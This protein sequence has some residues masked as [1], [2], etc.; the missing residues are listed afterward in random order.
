MSTHHRN[1]YR[2]LLKPATLHWLSCFWNTVLL[3]MKTTVYDDGSAERTPKEGAQNYMDL[4][5]F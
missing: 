5:K 3:W 4:V 2:W 1:V